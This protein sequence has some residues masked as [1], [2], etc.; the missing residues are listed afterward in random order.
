MTIQNRFYIPFESMGKDLNHVLD[1]A[2][3]CK[4][5]EEME[6]WCERCM[7]PQNIPGPAHHDDRGLVWQFGNSFIISEMNTV[8][9]I[10]RGIY[11]FNEEDRIAFKLAFSL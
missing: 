7:G 10:Y 9:T 4:I 6:E 11:I 1:V 2:G 5:Q 8:C 3:R